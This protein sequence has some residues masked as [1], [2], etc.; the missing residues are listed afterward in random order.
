MARAIDP[1]V[2]VKFYYLSP[3]LKYVLRLIMV[4]SNLFCGLECLCYL[5]VIKMH[6]IVEFFLTYCL[7]EKA[8]RN[9]V[10]DGVKFKYAE[11]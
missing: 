1:F 5:K 10:L 4:S 6:K 8:N 3:H 7:V 2:G 9:M 11:E